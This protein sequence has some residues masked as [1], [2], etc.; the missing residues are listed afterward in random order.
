MFAPQTR[1]LSHIELARSE[2]IDRKKKQSKNR[3]IG[4][5]L[6]LLF[7]LV[8]TVWTL[9]TFAWSVKC[10][11][12]KPKPILQAERARVKGNKSFYSCSCFFFC[13]Y[14]NFVDSICFRYAAN[15]QSSFFASGNPSR[16]S[17]IYCRSAPIRY[18]INPS[19]AKQTYRVRQHI[20]NAAGVYRKSRKGFI[21]MRV[22]R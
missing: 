13:R 9:L 20:S 3:R 6:L 16:S 18:E 4:F 22:L 10:K 21:S 14:V 15:P 8:K 17:S 2:Y 1:D 5:L 19:F 12:A 11:W 7:L